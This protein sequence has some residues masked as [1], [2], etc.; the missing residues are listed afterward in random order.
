MG[1]RAVV[2]ALMLNT[3]LTMGRKTLKNHFA[4]AICALAFLPAFFTKTPTL[5]IVVAAAL[6]GIIWNVVIRGGETK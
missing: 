1:I 3:V 2:C 4:Y 6:I 5:A